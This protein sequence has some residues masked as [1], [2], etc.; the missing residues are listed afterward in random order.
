MA[1][2][3]VHHTFTSMRTVPLRS[4]QT[5]S[6]YLHTIYR[7]STQYLHTHY[8]QDIHLCC[9]PITLSTLLLR[10]LKLCSL[11]LTLLVRAWC[12]ALCPSLHVSRVSHESRVTCNVSRVLPTCPPPRGRCPCA[13]AGAPPRGCG[14]AG[15][16]PSEQ[17][18][19]QERSWHKHSYNTGVPTAYFNNTPPAVDLNVGVSQKTLDYE[20]MATLGCNVERSPAML[21]LDVDLTAEETC[22]IPQILIA[23]NNWFLAFKHIKFHYMMTIYRTH[24][25]DK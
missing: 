19:P 3:V 6:H 4:Y 9:A 24:I 10:R 21:A 13:A 5:L 15:W 18:R 7:I 17:W 11:H 14:R 23:N 22:H 25:I 12:R 16:H 2:A 8:L 20:H 1:C